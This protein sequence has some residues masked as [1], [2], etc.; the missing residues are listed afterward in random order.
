MAELTIN[1]VTP[2][3]D[4]MHGEVDQVTAPSVVGEVGI[5]PGHLPLLAKLHEGPLGLHS[6]RGV[7]KYAVSGGFF[8][9]LGNVVTVLA[10]TAESAS[11]IDVDRAKRA[12]KDAEAQLKTLDYLDPEYAEQEARARRART[13]LLVAKV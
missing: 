1:V 10:D 9:V 12:L 13:R 6:D 11:E 2:D 4:V 8:E 7:Q 5:L 3:R